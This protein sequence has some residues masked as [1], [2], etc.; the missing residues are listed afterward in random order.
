MKRVL[1]IILAFYS[2]ANAQAYQKFHQKAILVDSHNDLLTASIEKNVQ[3]DQNLLGKTHSDIGRLIK[4]GVDVQIFSIWCDGDKKDPFAWANR[5]MD[6][7]DA[8]IARNPE[9]IIKVNNLV[10]LKAAIKQHKLAA[11]FGVEGGHMIEND[12]DKINRFYER[13]ARYLTLTWNN[14]TEWASSAMDENNHKIIGLTAFGKQVI[15]RMNKLGMLIDLSHVGE[16]TY[17]DA[18]KIS[19]KPVIVSHSN[20]YALCPVPRNLKDDQ[21]DAIKKNGG[22]IQLNFY[23]G[24]V[25][26][27]FKN[28]EQAFMEKYQTEIN[29]LVQK[30]MQKEYAMNSIVEKYQEEA[31]AIR[32]PL[33]LLMDHLD[34]IVQRIGVDYVG[35]GSDFDGITSTPQQLDDVMAYPLIT[36]S[37]IEKGYSKRA[38]KKILG[39]NFLRVLKANQQHEKNK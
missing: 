1:V 29:Q 22:V 35:M 2:I 30:G 13:G 32:P 17:K 38:I 33:S 39:G 7:L 5:E 8:A 25:D 16:E 20:V 21:I 31:N 36:K 19:T 37:L 6:S 14:S 15:E 9:K 26:S 23:A 24:F 28:R 11:M 3:I 18:I 34:Y 10:D 4:A 12:L 27:A